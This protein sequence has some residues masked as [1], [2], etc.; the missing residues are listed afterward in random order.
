VGA[1]ATPMD[2]GDATPAAS[3]YSS[4][5]AAP[6]VATSTVVPTTTFAPEVINNTG[7]VAQLEPTLVPELATSGSQPEATLESLP[8]AAQIEPE[9]ENVEPE[10]EVEQVV[11]VQEEPEVQAEVVPQPEVANQAEE[12]SQQSTPAQSSAPMSWA[13]RMRSAQPTG[14]LTGS[15]PPPQQQNTPTPPQPVAPVKAAPKPTSGP[16]ENGTG[17]NQGTQPE[18]EFSQVTTGR[19]HSNNHNRYR[20]ENKGHYDSSDRPPRREYNDDKQQIFV[21]GLPNNMTEQDIR[22][23][24]SKFGEV[25]HVRINTGSNGRP[26]AGFGFVTFSKEIEAK[27]ALN[28]K[29]NIYFKNLKIYFL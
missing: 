7:S 18:V 27:A 11:Q 16:V 1:P 21:G 19:E 13:A 2:N 12:K 15:N 22:D 8:V 10:V 9:I 23:T 26:G 28:D 25:R 29:D 5:Q 4:Y 20:G 17:S 24:F 14:S 6:V 3:I